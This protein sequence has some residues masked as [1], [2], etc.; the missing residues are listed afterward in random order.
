MP[1][2]AM[3]WDLEFLWRLMFGAWCFPLALLLCRHGSQGIGELRI[4][5]RL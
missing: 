4:I 1:I 2:R 5:A 3:L